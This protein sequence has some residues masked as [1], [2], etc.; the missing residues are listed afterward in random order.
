MAEVWDV[1]ESFFD[2]CVRSKQPFAP[3]IE[4]LSS[5]PYGLRKGVFPILLAAV[6]RSRLMVTSIWHDRSP[7]STI[8]GH[9]LQKIVENPAGYSIEI[10][11]WS[12]VLDCL[13]QVLMG[14][15]DEYIQDI[16][17]NKQLLSRIRSGM[18]RWL[19]GLPAFCRFTSQ[20][21]NQANEFRDMIRK[22][23]TEP[24]KAIFDTLP[25]VLELNEQSNVDEIAT[26][27]D[28]LM[29]E[30]SNAYYDLQRRLDVFVANEF[31]Y[32]GL[33]QDGLITL[34][35]WISGVHSD[36]G[37][38]ISEFKFSSTLTQNVVNILL[39]TSENDGSFW[40]QMAE[41]VL[42]VTLKDWNDNSETRFYDELRKARDEVERDVKELTEE[43]KAVL[44]AIHLPDDEPREFRFRS[45][46]LSQHGQR[47]LQN[48]KSTMEIAGRPLSVDER[49][50]IALAFL[51]HVMGEE[52]DD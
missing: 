5:S 1:I 20:I 35:S 13:W 8:D 11:Y 16:E 26:I 28:R 43:D 31:G 19:Q 39:D 30:I 41:A 27:I 33:T 22:A 23:Q 2:T 32:S 40:N 25:R 46:D 18:T 38:Q 29:Q 51:V 17:R 36:N 4:T 52:L 21:S 47:L 42:G 48:F 24:S 34:K 6:L 49:R 37:T 7:I 9:T 14:R 15:F 50:K 3:I 44:F 10:G 45:S 12:P